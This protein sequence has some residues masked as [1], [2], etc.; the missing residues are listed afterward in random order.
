MD[1]RVTKWIVVFSVV[2]TL[3]AVAAPV[4]HHSVIKRAMAW[5]HEHP[6]MG[7]AGRSV[8]SV[9]IFPESG[10]HFV[11]VVHLSPKGYL[12]LNS[13]EHP[14][15]V[16]SF[17][18]DASVDLSADPTNAF[19]SMLL[20]HVER[21]ER[22]PAQA[23]TVLG[24]TSSGFEAMTEM[25]GPFLD[26]TW[27]QG[28][29]Y[30]KMCQVVPDGLK[31]LNDR[32]PTGC[33]ATAYAQLLQFHRWPLFGK[34]AHAYTD[35]S[36]S[37]TG[38]HYAD[39]ADTYDWASMLTSYA[40]FN[41][42]PVEAE[43][44][45][46]E[47][48]RELGIAVEAN[49]EAGGTTASTWTL[50]DRLSEYFFFEP[51]EYHAWQA[52]LMASMARDLRAGFPCVVSIPGH[53]VV[54]DGLMVD[55]GV[56]TYHINFGWGGKNNGWWTVDN[57][58]GSPIESGITSL[59]PRLIA[60]PQTPVMHSRLGEPVDLRWLLPRQRENEA[61]QLN[62]HR[63]EQQAGIWQSDASDMAAGTTSHWH[64]VPGGHSGHCWF[65]GPNGR[66]WMMLD[67]V[68][69]PDVSTDLTFWLSRRL[70]MATFSVEVLADNGRT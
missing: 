3:H 29:P 60:M 27:N 9:E 54:T 18:P 58:A 65:A 67:E 61:T 33:V 5:M 12:I 25:H 62:I 11:Y 21:M 35:T 24:Q 22:Q 36:G 40:V 20:R 17:S 53:S 68:F 43:D 10:Q 57:V 6:V 52:D 47:L 39:F 49:Y 31:G 55:Q 26:T 56:T 30:N 70:G 15:S 13:N 1:A 34:G 7:P 46:A 51:I 23:R 66:A 44:A 50:G 38:T 32:A 69:V 37:V 4:Q 19:R 64:V 2:I 59:K 8:A 14:A 42:N 45:V 16:V 41:P 48:M 63:L 28:H